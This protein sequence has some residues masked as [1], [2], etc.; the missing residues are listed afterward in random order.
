MTILQLPQRPQI[1]AMRFLP[2]QPRAFNPARDANNQQ[3]Q[4]GEPF[5]VAEIET[6]ALSDALTG[7]YK[8]LNARQQGSLLTIY[9]YD[10]Q[11]QRPLMGPVGDSAKI[12]SVSRTNRTLTF[13]DLNP[14]AVISDGDY[15]SWDDGPARRLHILGGGVADGSGN[16]TVPCEPPPP[17]SVHADTTLPKACTFNR[18]SA[19]FQILDF[20][21]RFQA[22]VTSSAT[23][24][25]TSIIRRFYPS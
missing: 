6:T 21:M 16:L 5:W 4:M 24:K 2:I 13:Q 22:P 12:A 17:A 9:L 10:A 18:A 3:V 15:V 19:E 8:W 1:A 23:L 20:D 11:R 25:A 14:G 7:Q